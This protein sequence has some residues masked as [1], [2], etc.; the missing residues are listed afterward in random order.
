MSIRSSENAGAWYPIIRNGSVGF[1]Q[2]TRA[3]RV[4]VC[5]GSGGISGSKSPRSHPP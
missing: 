2:V 1:G 4:S 3:E 5:G